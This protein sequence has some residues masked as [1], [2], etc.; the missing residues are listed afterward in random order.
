MASFIPKKFDVKFL[1]VPVEVF[2][3]RNV[4]FNKDV[5]NTVNGAFVAGERRRRI[6]C[7]RLG[8]ALLIGALLTR[9]VLFLTHS[10]FESPYSLSGRVPLDAAPGAL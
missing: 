3:A 7:Y 10:H 1:L 9:A 2:F 4:D 5:V 6:V 8:V